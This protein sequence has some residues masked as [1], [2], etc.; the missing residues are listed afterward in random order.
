MVWD[1]RLGRYTAPKR[2]ATPEPFLRGPIPADWLK[3]A[4]QLP[5]KALHVGLVAWYVAG[6]RSKR[7][8]LP[9]SSER[10]AQF[11]VTRQ[12][13]YRALRALERAGLVSVK[14]NGNRAP[15]VTIHAKGKRNA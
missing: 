12:S 1:K 14:R 15:A 2:K 5:G 4:G 7:D 3:A 13:K 6:L 8:D 9:V 11:G 10:A